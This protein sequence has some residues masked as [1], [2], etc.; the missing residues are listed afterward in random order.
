M[1]DDDMRSPSG[2]VGPLEQPLAPDGDAAVLAGLIPVLAGFDPAGTEAEAIDRLRVLEELKSACAAAQARETAALRGLRCA[3]EASRG[4]PVRERGRGLGA[5]V[6]LARRISPQ[7]GSQEVGLARA[8]VEEMPH[9]LAALTSGEISEFKATIMARETAWLPVEARREVDKMMAGR[10]AVVGE[11]RLGGEARAHA[12]R[13][14]PAAAVKHTDRAVNERRVAVRP[15]PGGMAYLT[16]LL[17]MTQAVACLANLKRSAATTT[18]TGTATERTQDQIVA[19]LL[20]ER[21]TGQRTAQDVPVEVHLVM[22]DHALFGVDE[23][24]AW[25]VGHGPVPAGSARRV[26]RD[27][28]ADVFLRR[29]YTAP[30][31]GQLVRMDSKRREFTGMLRRMVILREDTCRTPWCDAPVRHIDH[32]TPARDGGSTDWENASGLC[33]ACNYA[34]E[35]PGWEHRADPG[36]LEVTTP[37]GHRYRQ[38]TG[39]LVIGAPPGSRRIPGF[40]RVGISARR[41]ERMLRAA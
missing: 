1:F 15:A 22:T 38:P 13:L 19:D 16:A 4:V 24:P 12:Q 39:Q 30:D 3:D 7:R 37:T 25:L 11:R 23:T 34:K 33:A 2:R 6:G 28:G 21:V 5:E 29:L 26:A 40:F 20:V 36:E 14:D 8:L 35:N 9:T 41:L 10:L 18:S 31:T 32:A 17:P 27:T